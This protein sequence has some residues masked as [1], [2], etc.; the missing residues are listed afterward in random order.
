MSDLASEAS[1][2]I[3]VDTSRA[4]A[5]RDRA[6]ELLRRNTWVLSAFLLLVLFIATTIQQN[7]NIGLTSQ[8]AIAAPMTLAALASAPSII[9][10]GFDLSI[11]PLLVFTNCV[12][13]VWLAPHH[14]P[15]GG[16]SPL[17]GSG[18][19]PP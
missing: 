16:S 12:Y 1:T 3:A 17:R 8:L 13:V 2:P 18:R 6:T 14:R 5:A 10:G 15:R 9:G 7:G 11:S 4:R 19:P